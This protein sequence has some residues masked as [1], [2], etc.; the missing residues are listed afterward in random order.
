MN[1]VLVEPEIPPN[2]GNVARTCVLTGT[3]LHLVEPLGFSLAEKELRRSGLDYWKYLDLKVHKDFDTFLNN[4]EEGR[5]ISFSTGSA[6]HYHRCTYRSD[7]YLVYGSE[8]RGLN[9]NI[10]KATDLTLRIPMLEQIPR[11]LNLGNSVAI[12][13]YEA[14]RQQNFPGMR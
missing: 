3:R 8:T 10:I 9:V 12:V 4:R 11:S 7:D 5:L 13:L 6:N 14:L 2:T 1:I